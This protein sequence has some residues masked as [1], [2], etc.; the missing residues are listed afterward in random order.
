MKKYFVPIH[1]IG[2]EKSFNELK[3]GLERFEGMMDIFRTQ[4][5]DFE[6]GLR[7]TV[8]PNM[9]DELKHELRGLTARLP[10]D[11]WF[12]NDNL[13]GGPGTSQSM[14]LLNPSFEGI[15]ISVCLDQYIHDSNEAVSR[16][17]DL[18]SRVETNNSLYATG[19][20]NVPVILAQHKRNSDLRIIHELFH[21]LT[22]GSSNLKV[23]ERLEGVTPAYAEIGESGA[24]LDMINHYHSE[25]PELIRGL[26]EASQTAD[27]R[28]FA[29]PYYFAL[30]SGQLRGI[31]AN[32][33]VKAKENPF[34]A[35]KKPEEQ[36]FEAIKKMISYQTQQLSGTD[37]AGMLHAS[38]MEPKNSDAISQFYPREDVEIV[39]DTMLNALRGPF[40]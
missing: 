5:P 10:L 24:G 29:T 18:A 30:K 39:R 20:R 15:A 32:G 21:S 12:A 1:W 28:G 2:E 8:A 31:T 25:F 4:Y 11:F 38:L 37:V 17:A 19:S 26:A 6:F 13:P 22:I 33:Y 7:L 23:Q 34:Y 35:G 3:S 9:K 14:V 36:E 27:M 40:K 16:V